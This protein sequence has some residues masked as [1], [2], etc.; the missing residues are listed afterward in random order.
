[1]SQ[2]SNTTDDTNSKPRLHMARPSGAPPAAEKVPPAADS[3]AAVPRF[4]FSRKKKEDDAPAPAAAPAPVSP[5]PPTPAAPRPP[6]GS[7]LF[8]DTVAAT[9]PGATPAPGTPGARAAT[10]A[11]FPAKGR[12]SQHSHV[13]LWIAIGILALAV[14]AESAYILMHDEQIAE[15][16]RQRPPVVV[17]SPNPAE[18]PTDISKESS[19]APTPVVAYLQTLDLTV[20]SG[21]EP[22]LFV[23]NQTF[24]LGDVVA[25]NLGLKWT[26]LND[27]TRELEFTDKQGHRYVKKF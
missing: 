22:R 21:S 8:P 24:H 16:N 12:N 6:G 3:S 23:N 27:Q 2:D 15:E 7:K 4:S 9:P 17:N 26:H 14:G 25:P 10:P 18:K 20:A 13:K 1:M 19:V 11:P 5:P